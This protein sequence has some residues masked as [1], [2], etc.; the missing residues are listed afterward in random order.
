LQQGGREELRGV[1]MLAAGLHVLVTGS[2]RSTDASV[3]VTDGDPLLS[4]PM[5]ST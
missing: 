3:P 2:H 5:A 4:P 1:L